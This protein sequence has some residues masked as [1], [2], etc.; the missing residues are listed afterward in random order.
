MDNPAFIGGSNLD[1]TKARLL[2]MACL[3]KFGSLCCQRLTLISPQ[4]RKRR[5]STRRSQHIK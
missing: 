4:R 5:L 3:M 1:R 2:L